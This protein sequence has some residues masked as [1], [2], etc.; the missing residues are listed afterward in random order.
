MGAGTFLV[1]SGREYGR[2]LVAVEPM[3]VEERLPTD[4]VSSTA[5]T[6]LGRVGGRSDS[7]ICPSGVGALIFTI[8][9]N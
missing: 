3:G 2:T 9:D 8:D 1:G 7:G 5:D 4:G 6:K